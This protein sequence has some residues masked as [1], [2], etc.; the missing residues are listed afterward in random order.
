MLTIKNLHKQ[1]EFR[2]KGNI[3][4]LNNISL[5]VTPG[6]FV[7]IVGPSGSGKTTFLKIIAG[8]DKDYSGTVNW[9][10]TSRSIPIGFVFQDPVLFPWRTVLKN[11]LLPAEIDK[12]F[13]KSDLA[14]SYLEDVGLGDD[15]S[16]YPSQLSGGMKARV[17]IARAFAMQPKMLLMDEPFGA[18]DEFT[19]IKLNEILFK[20]WEKTRPTI[21]FVTHKIS[22]AISLSDRIIVF[23]NK[24]VIILKDI[25][26]NLPRPR[27]DDIKFSKEFY[28]YEKNIYDLISN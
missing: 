5:K 20:I 22:E 17:A 6:Q 27:N 12:S 16:S 25:T 14:Q 28:Q 21:L 3:V 15:L 11:T 13:M 10:N 18:L 4:V 8:L 7:S 1:F 19:R 23:S 2:H 9:E 26:V 24:P